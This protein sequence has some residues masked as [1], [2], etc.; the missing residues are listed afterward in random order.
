MPIFVDRSATQTA[1]LSPGLKKRM[2]GDEFSQ[3]C[4]VGGDRSDGKPGMFGATE[5]PLAAGGMGSHD[6]G[7]RFEGCAHDASLLPERR[8]MAKGAHAECLL[9]HPAIQ[10]NLRRR[11]LLHGLFDEVFSDKGQGRDVL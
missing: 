8:V 1:A 10:R 5:V 7:R 6:T 4:G 3:M 9:L 2:G 11:K